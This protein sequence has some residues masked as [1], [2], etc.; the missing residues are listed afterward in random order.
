MSAEGDYALPVKVPPFHLP[1]K[2]KKKNQGPVLS[3]C[4]KVLLFQLSRPFQSVCYDKIVVRGRNG[5]I[6]SSKILKIKICNGAHIF[7]DGK[8]VPKKT[9]YG[10]RLIII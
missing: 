1:H 2:V 8:H 4:S 6:S 9:K 7:I 5:T 3:S 10:T